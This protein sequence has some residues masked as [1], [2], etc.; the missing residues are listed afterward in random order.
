MMQEI[1]LR[2]GNADGRMTQ[3][4]VQC[5]ACGAASNTRRPNCLMCG[6]ALAKAHVF[7]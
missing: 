7:E 6:T 4:I 5:P 1:D 3:R 2:D